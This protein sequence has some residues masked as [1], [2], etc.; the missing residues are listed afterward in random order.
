MTILRLIIATPI[1]GVLYGQLGYR[2]PFIFGM[3][4]AFVDLIGRLLVI[5]KAD[6]D[7][8]WSQTSSEV[9]PNQYESKRETGDHDA[10][11]TTGAIEAMPAPA[12]PEQQS[13]RP[14]SPVVPLSA[15]QIMRKLGLSVRPVAVLLLTVVW[16]CV[17]I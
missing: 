13:P 16:G 4:I 1:G 7:K 6:A 12:T 14:L 3:I 11:D 5:E 17:H 9:R 2:A 10:H 15:F 8:L